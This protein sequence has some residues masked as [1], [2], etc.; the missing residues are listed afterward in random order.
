MAWFP[1]Q[2]GEPLARRTTASSPASQK[3]RHHIL[4]PSGGSLQWTVARSRLRPVGRI[5]GNVVVFSMRARWN[6]ALMSAARTRP[7][8]FRPSSAQ[9]GTRR[10]AMLAYPGI[11]ILDVV[12][13]LEVFSRTARWLKD[14]GHR[15][16]DA[17]RVEI[18]GVARG[19]FRASSGL[20]LYADHRFH[21]VKNGIDT[22]LVAGGVGMERFR[23][24]A[25]L[26][27]WLRRQA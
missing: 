16:D 17:Y 25:P 10:I 21:E 9:S 13:P 23:T 3:R 26:L 22:L 15:A 12:G 4:H 8:A 5:C 1:A 7:R 18:L 6:T 24:H 11:Q 19:A 27:R 2:A 20:R 14:H